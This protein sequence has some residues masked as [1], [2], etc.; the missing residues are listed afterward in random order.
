[1]RILE[2]LA[3]L[4]LRRISPTRRVG[5]WSPV[6]ILDAVLN[7]GDLQER[8]V[9]VLSS[10]GGPPWLAQGVCNVRTHALTKG[11]RPVLAKH[12]LRHKSSQV[13]LFLYSTSAQLAGPYNGGRSAAPR[14]ERR[15]L[16]RERTQQER[17]G[18]P[19]QR[20]QKTARG[21]ASAAWSVL[22]VQAEARQISPAVRARRDGYQ[23]GDGREAAR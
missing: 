10:D 9:V 20:R 8:R 6:P 5:C 11:L 23:G 16:E 12:G 21:A 18:A 4:R 19:A 3:K 17:T 2:E 14:C 15:W 13:K 22:R 7:T 1:M